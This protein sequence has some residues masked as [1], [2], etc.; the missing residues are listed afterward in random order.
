MTPGRAEHMA[1]RLERT[2]ARRGVGE[3]ELLRTAHSLAME[4]RR[5]GLPDEDA[6]QYLHPGRTAIVAMTEGGV[7][8]GR[9]VAAALFFESLDPRLSVTEEPVRAVGDSRL[10]DAWERAVSLPLP[11]APDLV[12]TLV[13]AEPETV[14]IVLAE[15]LD[16]LRH[17][18]LWA[19][20]GLVAEAHRL[21]REVYLP[22]ADRAH[23]T[24]AR[25]LRW[26]LRR[27]PER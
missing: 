3:I 20:G 4:P 16:Q 5:R 14:A 26:W 11:G 19:A 10:D 24:L 7:S 8:D 15:W 25:R 17:V 27:V 21:T 12:E 23:E 2:A 1:L 9:L 6:P 13:T 18:R 22:V